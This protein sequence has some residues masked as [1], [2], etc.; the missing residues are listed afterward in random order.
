MAH[1][2]GDFIWYELMTN[3]ADAA[4]DFYGALLGWTFVSSGLDG[5]DYR[6]FSAGDNAVG[7]VMALTPEMQQGGA[8]PCWAGYINVEDVDRMAQ[9]IQSSNG[10]VH[11]EPQD[12]PEVGRF[13]FVADPQGALFYVMKPVPHADDPGRSS[14]SFAATEPM[15]GH[16]AWNELATSDPEAAMNFYH[17]L[18][19]WAKDGEMD[20][21]E[22]GK[23]EFLRHDF[24]IGAMM[25]KTPQ[26]PVS[27]WSYYFRVANIDDAIAAINAHG[28]KVIHGPNEIPG[29]DF[30][31]TGVDPQ[32]A[33]F[34]LVGAK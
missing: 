31:M 28:G 34:S 27:S 17:D 33:I 23:Y 15:V 13:A 8:K 3:D 6:I 24:M 26:M 18:F 12:I 22:M 25:L 5:M 1:K 19:G 16:C 29:G 7:G 20:M 4:Q 30:S 32:G 10:S 21:G 2:H 14:K 11:M 9:A